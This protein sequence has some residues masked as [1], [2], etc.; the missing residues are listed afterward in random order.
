MW[1]F[2]NIIFIWNVKT[3][4]KISIDDCLENEYK[5]HTKNKNRKI[6]SKIRNQVK[7]SKQKK[8]FKL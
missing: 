2:K 8:M 7:I 4:L 1:Y 6:I 3:D 5:V